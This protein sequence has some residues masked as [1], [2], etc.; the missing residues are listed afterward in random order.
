MN[1]SG[2]LTTRAERREYAGFNYSSPQEECTFVGRLDFRNWY[3]NNNVYALVC[4]FTSAEGRKF[5]LFAFRHKLPNE[6]YAP[7]SCEIDFAH[8]VEDGSIWRCTSVYTRYGQLYWKSAELVSGPTDDDSLLR[9]SAIHTITMEQI[10]EN[11]AKRDQRKAQKAEEDARKEERRHE[12]EY[13]RALKQDNWYGRRLR[14]VK[15]F[16]ENT[17]TPRHMKKYATENVCFVMSCDR[18]TMCCPKG[19]FFNTH[20]VKGKSRMITFPASCQDCEIEE[21]QGTYQK[22]LQLANDKITTRESYS[23][24]CSEEDEDNET[25]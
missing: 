11:I 13:R 15:A 23:R 22:K 5:S 25:E 20:D 10:E 6:I 8:D 3:N 12:R 1:K 16:R 2:V 24:S 4:N 21:C 17:L 14:L 9:Y 7:R 18:Q 19:I